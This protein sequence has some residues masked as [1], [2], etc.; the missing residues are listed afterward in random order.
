[1]NDKEEIEDDEPLSQDPH[2]RDYQLSIRL[3][4]SKNEY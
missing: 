3:T 4:G 2:L 1:M